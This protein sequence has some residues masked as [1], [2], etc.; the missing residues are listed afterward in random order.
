MTP[1]RLTLAQLND[2]VS[3]AREVLSIEQAK[4]RIGSTPPQA[5]ITLGTQTV[6]V[7]ASREAMR[8]ELDARLQPAL[9]HLL[10]LGIEL[11]PTQPP[12]PNYAL[13]SPG[14]L[15]GTSQQGCVNRQVAQLQQGCANQDRGLDK[16]W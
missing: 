7:P 8:A 13:T 6:W 15:I 16:T 14:K 1:L 3:L 12:A 10:D 5:C 2:A 4:D 9:K 11:D